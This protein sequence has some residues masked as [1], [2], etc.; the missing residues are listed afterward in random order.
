MVEA[1]NTRESGD[2]VL[3]IRREETELI[4][5]AIVVAGELVECEE[6]SDNDLRSRIII[7]F[8]GAVDEVLEGSGVGINDRIE[9][10][11]NNNE[12]LSEQVDNTGTKEQAKECTVNRGAILNST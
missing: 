1:G 6:G 12:N 4:D 11:Y 7:G 5:G 8:G 9:S 2:E 3:E 10:S